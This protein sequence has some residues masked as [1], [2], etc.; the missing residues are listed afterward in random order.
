MAVVFHTICSFPVSSLAEESL[1]EIS[2]ML[3]E[4]TKL[5]EINE[6]ASLLV[7][8]FLEFSLKVYEDFTFEILQFYSYVSRHPS[9]MLE[10]A[11]R[12]QG[13]L[14]ASA[15]SSRYSEQALLILLRICHLKHASLAEFFGEKY[16]ETLLSK[17]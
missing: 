12:I 11:S 13:K 8:Y 15:L 6:L 9:Q 4:W 1:F 17:F 2:Y 7:R 14:Q 10:I 16:V 3:G 5:T